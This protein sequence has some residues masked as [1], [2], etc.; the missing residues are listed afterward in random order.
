[1]KKDWRKVREDIKKAEQKKRE[2]EDHLRS[3]HRQARQAE[4]AEIIASI[5]G[6]TQKGGDV[7]ETL[8]NIQEKQRANEQARGPVIKNYESEV[9]IDD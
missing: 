7:M 6:M 3:L 1:M 4:D 8:K 2:T 9:E 5:R